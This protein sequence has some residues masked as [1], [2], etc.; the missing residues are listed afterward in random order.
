MCSELGLR[1]VVLFG[2]RVTGSP[3]PGSDSEL[4]VAVLTD[5]ARSS[6]PSSG[7]GTRFHE[8]YARLARVFS[9]HSLDLAFLDD[10]E[11][12]FRWE[13]VR[14]GVLLRGDPDAWAHYQAFAYRAYVDSADL[15]ALEK[16]LSEK[17]RGRLRRMVGADG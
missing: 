5:R 9:D 12:L 2:S 8:I 7:P 11:P 10:A 17:K 14:E 6:D 16:T 15:R 1:A 4:D 3:V 13:V